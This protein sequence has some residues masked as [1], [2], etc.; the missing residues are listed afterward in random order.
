MGGAPVHVWAGGGITVMADV[1]RLPA[2]SFGSV[3]TPALVAPIEFT[4]PKE[5]YLTLGGHGSDIVTIND[6]L[7]AV[8]DTARIEAWQERNP[9][10]LIDVP[11]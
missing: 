3:P 4:L 2:R 7:S 11:R 5:L 8:G 10:P 9:W 6:V 1:A